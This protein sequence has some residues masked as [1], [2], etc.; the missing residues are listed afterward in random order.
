VRNY[1]DNYNSDTNAGRE[2]CGVAHVAICV[3]FLIA[4]LFKSPRRALIL[5]PFLRRLPFSKLRLRAICTQRGLPSNQSL[6]RG[7]RYR[8]SVRVCHCVAIWPSPSMSTLSYGPTAN[9]TK[10]MCHSGG[11]LEIA[12]QRHRVF[13]DMTFFFDIVG[14]VDSR[15]EVSVTQR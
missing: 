9:H 11:R 2:I 6:T 10:T 14:L 12:I 1:E 8:A 7:R 15:V 5:Y 3:L 4:C 13:A